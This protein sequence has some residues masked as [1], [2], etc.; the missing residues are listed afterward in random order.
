MKRVLC[1]T[2]AVLLV[3]TCFAGCKVGSFECAICQEETFGIKNE[4]EILGEKYAYCGDCKDKI[5][6]FKKTVE[7]LKDSLGDGIDIFKD[8]LNEKL[9][10]LKDALK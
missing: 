3:A 8:A 10:D 9:D 5:D 7:G 4:V 6:D 1:L 2:L